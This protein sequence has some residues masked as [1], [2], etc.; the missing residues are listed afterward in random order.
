MLMITLMM[1]EDNRAGAYQ[2]FTAQACRPFA[3]SIHVLLLLVSLF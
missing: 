1:I 3:R 2:S